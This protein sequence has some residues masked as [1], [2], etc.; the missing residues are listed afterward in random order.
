MTFKTQSPTHH[1]TTQASLSSAPHLQQHVTRLDPSV[2][3]H[4]SALHDGADVDAAIASLITL[5]H[6]AD[7]QEVVLL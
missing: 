7:A 2:S 6:N 4:G 1:S 3:C 5:T